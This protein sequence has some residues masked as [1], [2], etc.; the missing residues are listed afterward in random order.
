MTRRR[1][2]EVKLRLRKHNRCN[3]FAFLSFTFSLPHRTKSIFQFVVGAVDYKTCGK[4][5]NT[6]FPITVTP[7]HTATVHGLIVNLWKVI[8]STSSSSYKAQD[9]TLLYNTV[10]SLA[11]WQ[12]VT[13]HQY[14][15]YVSN[16]I[17]ICTTISSLLQ[18]IAWLTALINI[19][20]VYCHPLHDWWTSCSSICVKID[21]ENF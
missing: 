19:L 7:F 6:L 14:S 20:D 2:L 15:E 21:L 1:N 3:L 16:S 13:I 5:T 10:Y 11:L 9:T 4:Q 18:S 8:S 12:N 17:G